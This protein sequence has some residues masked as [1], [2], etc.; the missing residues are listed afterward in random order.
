VQNLTSSAVYSVS[1]TNDTGVIEFNYK[2][3][4]GKSKFTFLSIDLIPETAFSALA[5]LFGY[6]HPDRAEIL[7]QR[8]KVAQANSNQ[9]L[10]L[11]HY[12]VN[13]MPRRERVFEGKSPTIGSISKE[14]PF[15][16]FLCGHIHQTNYYNMQKEG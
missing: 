10:V 3:P 16:A 8:L 4:S 12:P 15:L 13:S 1:G 7:L 5:D 2:S 6:V 9:T 14:S 11:G